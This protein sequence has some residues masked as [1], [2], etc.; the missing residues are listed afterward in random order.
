[1]KFETVKYR[2]LKWEKDW[3]SKMTQTCDIG[4]KPFNLKAKVKKGTSIFNAAK[5]Q[6][7]VLR[8]DCGEK[9]TC[10]KCAVIVEN[11]ENLSPANRAEK[12]VL[13]SSQLK[14][15]YRLACQAE[16]L[17]HVTITIPEDLAISSEV[18]GKAGMQGIFPVNPG[19]KRDKQ[20]SLGFAFD[21]GT[22]TIAAYLCDLKSGRILTSKAIVNPQRQYGEDVIARI[23]AV[24]EDEANLEKQQ[25]LAVEA[26]NELIKFCLETNRSVK[27]DIDEITVVGNT[28][29]EHI[30]AGLNPKNIGVS[31]YL[32]VTNSS[33][34]TNAHDLG[35][36]LPSEVSVYIFPVI[37]G[38]LGGDILS[39]L[40]ADQSH[41]RKE[42]SLIIDI[43]TNGELMLCN[44]K[45]MW[46]TSCATGPALEGAQISCGM[47][48]SSGAISKVFFH[49]EAENRIVFE[50]IG[51]IEARGV[52]GSG[53][54]DALA[55][56]RKA[57]VTL[58]N[59]TFN[60]DHPNVVCNA[61]GVGKKFM[62][63]KSH[64]YITLKDVRQ[65]QLANAALIV[66]IESLLEKAGVKQVD[67]TILTG[68]FGAK[69]NWRNA[70]DIGMLP[71]LILKGKVESAQNLAGTGAVIALLDVDKRVEIATIARRINFLDL[72]S[73]P[74]FTLKFSAATQFPAIGNFS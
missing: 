47:R 22:T 46:G 12:K 29:M 54:I 61:K 66:G 3:E 62:F 28:T 26:M 68:A 53:I 4:F 48:A 19:A 51:N 8:S 10:G 33:V 42:T 58:E 23:A 35:L 52:C 32:P 74:D 21:I 55:A 57:D 72:S 65:V 45:G 17:G 71:G 6:N 7:I 34:V 16:V 70:R 1:L 13:S 30:L 2:E 50:T 59:G 27:K 60:S 25:K 37:S 38:F 39:A 20:T 31:P 69:F 43:G 41:K 11:T 5:M 14:S 36:D 64:V 67:R 40:L 49:P 56:M 73:E 15:F 63:P 44:N 24:N 9:G 18:Y